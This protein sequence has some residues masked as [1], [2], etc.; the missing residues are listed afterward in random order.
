MCGLLGNG[1]DD[2]TDEVR[3]ISLTIAVVSRWADKLKAVVGHVRKGCCNPIPNKNRL[4]LTFTATKASDA[5]TNHHVFAPLKVCHQSFQ[6]ELGFYTRDKLQLEGCA[7]F[8]N[9]SL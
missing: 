8:S 5:R 3:N 6:T 7:S 2:S 1:G 4:Y 9:V